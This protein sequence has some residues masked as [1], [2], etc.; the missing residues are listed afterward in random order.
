MGCKKA[1]KSG[2]SL[3]DLALQGLKHPVV[4]SLSYKQRKPGH[5]CQGE[6]KNKWKD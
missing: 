1:A 4:Q 6:T 5:V 2:D 3:L